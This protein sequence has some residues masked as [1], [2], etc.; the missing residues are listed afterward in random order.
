MA[1]CVAVLAPPELAAEVLPAA[2]RALDD[3]HLELRPDKTQA[4]SRRSPCPPGLEA[5]WQ[6]A[7]LTLVGAPLGEPLPENGLPEQ[8]DW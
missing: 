6:P 4:W 3:L 2:Q 8:R 1:Q 5:Q 7:G